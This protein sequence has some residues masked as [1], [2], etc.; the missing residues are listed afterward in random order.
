MQLPHSLE[1]G[2]WAS[3]SGLS[4]CPAKLEKSVIVL[5]QHSTLRKVVAR[6]LHIPCKLGKAFCELSSCN[7]LASYKSLQQPVK[8]S[9]VTFHVVRVAF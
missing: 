3:L 4:M 1:T 7:P 2:S 8:V 6:D 5:V 9:C